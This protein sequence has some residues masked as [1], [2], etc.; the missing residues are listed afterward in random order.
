MS[1]ECSP[2]NILNNFIII[3][4]DIIGYKEG[5]YN[6]VIKNRKEKKFFW[7]KMQNGAPDQRLGATLYPLE[8]VS[9]RGQLCDGS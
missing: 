1:E 3:Y 6:S 9:S 5:S 8:P 4:L 7:G 2:L